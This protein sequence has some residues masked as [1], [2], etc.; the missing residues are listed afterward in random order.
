MN[1]TIKAISVFCC[2]SVIVCATDGMEGKHIRLSPSWR[3]GNPF[4]PLAS[5]TIYQKMVDGETLRINE[6]SC[7]LSFSGIEG[8]FNLYKASYECLLFCESADLFGSKAQIGSVAFLTGDSKVTRKKFFESLDFENSST[9][10]AEC[11][12]ISVIPS[13]AEFEGVVKKN[14]Y[15]ASCLITG[16]EV[17]FTEKD[18]KIVCSRMSPVI[19]NRG[20]DL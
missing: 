20:K 4:G 15:A 10:K 17:E 11:T 19:K 9:T 12:Y 7:S 16:L 1:N 13:F 14:D 2:V 3:E 8:K 6:K 18:K 5:S